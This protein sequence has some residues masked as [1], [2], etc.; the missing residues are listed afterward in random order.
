MNAIS[1][2][3]VPGD[4]CVWQAKARSEKKRAK[5]RK[6]LNPEEEEKR[7]VSSRLFYFQ[8]CLTTAQE[9]L[10]KRRQEKQQQKAEAYAKMSPEEQRR[11]DEKVQ[12]SDK[13][14][15]KYRW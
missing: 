4:S 12:L 8:L 13:I 3:M 1:L 11:Y 6:A 2:I 7:Q 9:L 10:E 15:C 5:A 14:N